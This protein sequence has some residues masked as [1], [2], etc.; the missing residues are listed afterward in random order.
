MCRTREPKKNE[1]M[2]NEQPRFYNSDSFSL[3]NLG[4]SLFIVH[5]ILSL[6]PPWLTRENT[7]GP[8]LRFRAVDSGAG[9]RV[10]SR[11][12]GG[13]LGVWVSAHPGGR[14]GDRVCQQC[15][16]TAERGRAGRGG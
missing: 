7:H 8:P 14:A 16:R 6:L 1:Q 5:W 2:K 13:L 15:A 9:A 4:C 3:F 12:G 11:A 10:L